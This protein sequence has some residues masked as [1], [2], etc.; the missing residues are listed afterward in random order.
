MNPAVVKS[1]L[2]QRPFLKMA[3][4]H[5]LLS[6]T[7][8]KEQLADLYGKMFVQINVNTASD[9]EIL[10]DPRRWQPHDARVPR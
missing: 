8:S 5:A 10:S 1:I 7:L 9:E 2:E 6:K 3:D 4:L